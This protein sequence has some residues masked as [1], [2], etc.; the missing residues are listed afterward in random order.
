MVSLILALSENRVIGKDNQLPWHLPDDFAYF[1]RTT[2]GHP[3][4]M[5]RKSF[6]SLGKPLPKRTNI[7]VTR[8]EDYRPKGCVVVHSVEEA[9]QVAKAE[10]EEVYVI[11]GA[12][13]VKKAFPL[14]DTMLLTEVHA[15]VEGDTYF[16]EYNKSEWEE[17]SRE[18]HPT[19]ERHQYA[20]SFVRYDR[21]ERS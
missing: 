13:I 14:V 21:K 11:G 20:F 2:L 3:I 9:L 4:I 7:V 1:K 10:D 18:Y 6:K 8:Q 5:G 19:D 17:K 12:E 16:P 15:E